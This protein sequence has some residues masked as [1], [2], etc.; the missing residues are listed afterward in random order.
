MPTPLAWLSSFT[1]LVLMSVVMSAA[2]VSDTAPVPDTAA[3]NIIAFNMPHDGWATLAIDDQNGRRV[4]NLLADLPYT[5]GMQ[6]V[7]W[8]GRDDAGNVLPAGDY[9]WVGLNRKDI[10]A[11]YRGTF[12][13]GSPPWLYGKTG[14]WTGDHSSATTVVA[15]GNRVLIGSN[16]A[17]WGHG[18]IASNLDGRKEWGVKWLDRRPWCGAENLVVA[19]ERVFANS[20][21]GESAIWEIDPATGSNWLVLT[22]DDFPAATREPNPS[23]RVAGAHQVADGVELYVTTFGGDQRTLVFLIP[24]AP[25][26]AVY[27]RTLPL[28]LWSVVWQADGRAVAATDTGVVRLDTA[29]GATSTFTTAAISAPWCVAVDAQDR[30]YVSDQGATPL[31]ARQRDGQMEHRYL[32]LDRPAVHQILVF[33]ADGRRLCALGHLGGQA[34]SG[35]IDP[36]SFFQPAGIAIDS[37]GHLWVTE[38]TQSPRRVSVWELT[39]PGVKNPRLVD[40][41][42]GPAMY[43]GGAAMVDPAKPWELMDTYN[44]VIF[45]VDLTANRFSAVRLPWR[46]RDFWKEQIP[47]G[48]MPFAGRPGVVIPIGGRQYAAAQ[49]GY[50]HT[51][52]TVWMPNRYSSNGPVMIGEYVKGLFL[53][54]AAVGNIRMWLRGRSLQTRCEDQWLATPV[55]EAARRLPQWPAYA[56][57]MGIALDAADV[58]HWVHAKGAPFFTAVTWPQAISGM[59]WTDGNG[60][61]RMQAAEVSFFPMG[62]SG[63][64]TL[65]GD[66]NAFICVPS[67]QKDLTGTWRL[68]RRGFNADGAP[69]YDLAGLK[70]ISEQ[71]LGPT[72]I[73]AD[74]SLLSYTALYTAD[75]QQRWSYPNSG[76]GVRALGRNSRQVLNPGSIHR[77]NAMQGVVRASPALGDVYMLASIDGMNYLM[78]REDGLFIATLFRP[79]PFADGWDSQPE[80]TSGLR[81][82]RLSRQDEC[83]NAHFV[84]A[85]A[86]G[87]GFQSGHNYLIG[88]G[89]SAVVEITGLEGVARFAGGAL[90][91]REK[92]GFYGA[93]TRFDPAAKALSLPVQRTVEPLEAMPNKAGLDLFRGQPAKVGAAQVWVG[94]RGDG[95]HFKWVIE[96]QPAFVNLGTDWSQLFATGDGVEVQIKSPVLGRL[97]FIAAPHDG[98]PIIVRMRYDGTVSPAAVTYRSEVHQCSVP[99]VTIVQR[100]IT[101]SSNGQSTLVQFCLP[102]SDLGFTSVP[103]A[104]SSIP[105]ELGIF[106]ADGGGTRTRARE[107]WINGTGMVADLPTEA[108]PARDWGKLVLL[109]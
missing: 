47:S 59:V 67:W 63:V 62:D 32:R 85:A 66:L 39:E 92:V 52:D 41:F 50:M 45:D 14:G 9:R 51:D 43:G 94:W 93:G 104:G 1:L 100:G 53:P 58:P 37:R 90:T 12:Q 79:Y 77:V 88:N 72:Q 70:R 19:G 83:F 64:V 44:G 95:L 87:K 55:L 75:G 103:A 108:D 73:G 30:V 101:V 56:Q 68:P 10:A 13:H 15:V 8:D 99:E 28:R 24:S 7:E 36:T 107:F 57:A 78:T 6:R 40:Q 38:L 42:F 76:D 69:M 98:N 5:A 82:D 48:D 29:T 91:L 33:S 74:G 25:G 16:E 106:Q 86:S 35:P 18:L 23:P 49:G 61:G 105:L 20:Y 31:H 97:R 4:R 84:Q 102:W 89:R 65:D 17:E 96:G 3:A 46:P 2:T 22:I 21:F 26:K 27:R 54:R 80:A 71:D 60:D 11:E 109:P 81:L 34:V